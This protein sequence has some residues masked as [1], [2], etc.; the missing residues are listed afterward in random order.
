MDVECIIVPYVPEKLRELSER[1][2]NEPGPHRETGRTL[3]SWFGAQRRGSL[4]CSRIHRALK[5]VGLEAPGFDTLW[6]DVQISFTAVTPDICSGSTTAVADEHIMIEVTD[7]FPRIGALE[8]ANRK[9][10][11]VK[12][13]DCIEK[14]ITQMLLH[15]YS[16][17]PV[18]HSDREVKGYISWKTIEFSRIAKGSEPQTVQDCMDKY[19]DVLPSDATLFDATQ[20]MLQKEFI[21]VKQNDNMICGP[22]TLHDIS[23]QF[24]DLSESFLLLGTIENNLRQLL[25]GKFT[26]GELKE[27]VDLSDNEREI[28]DL[29]DLSFGEYIRLIDNHDQWKRLQINLDRTIVVE[30]LHDVRK[31]RNDVMHFRPDGTAPED[32]KLLKETATFLQQAI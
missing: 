24:R 5:E 28:N 20:R 15:D 27:C 13:E 18:M 2:K 30:Q 21:L 7:P 19:V 32:I 3:L 9:P 22:V 26:R 31:I 4:T 6:L 8:A 10:L 25:S 29:T 12:R 16:Q 23:A 14:A 1:V 11:S 17:L